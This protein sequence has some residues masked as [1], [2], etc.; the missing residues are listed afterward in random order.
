MYLNQQVELNLSTVPSAGGSESIDCQQ[1]EVNLSTI[2]S[3]GK[4]V[5]LWHI[6]YVRKSAGGIE[7]VDSPISKWK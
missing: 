6:A 7:S 2:P 1:V 4:S 3:A 5:N